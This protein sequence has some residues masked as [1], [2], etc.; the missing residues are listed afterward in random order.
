MATKAK[1]LEKPKAIANNTR[2]VNKADK[3]GSRNTS[4][5]IIR[6]VAVFF[7]VSIHFFLTMAITQKIMLE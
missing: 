2:S 1:T 3:L 6:I 4:M 7:V 5:D